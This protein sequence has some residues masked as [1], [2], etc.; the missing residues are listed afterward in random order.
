M[1][2]TWVDSTINESIMDDFF[3]YRRPSVYYP[4]ALFAA[5]AVVATLGDRSTQAGAVI[6]VQGAATN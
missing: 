4:T 3:N 2:L 5:L 6:A 1:A